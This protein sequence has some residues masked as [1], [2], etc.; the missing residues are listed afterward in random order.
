MIV[1]SVVSPAQTVADPLI[2]ARGN[3]LTSVDDFIHRVP[4]L[5]MSRKGNYAN[6]PMM[7]GL[8]INRM[9]VNI[10]GSHVNVE[11]V[12]PVFS[13][14]SPVKK[15]QLVYAALNEQIADGT[16]HAVNMRTLTPEQKAAQ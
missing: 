9:A 13:G 1:R 5:N 8:N 2:V 6:E 3:S 15:Q 10:D 11:V 7:R 16:I 14:L 4:G 12:S